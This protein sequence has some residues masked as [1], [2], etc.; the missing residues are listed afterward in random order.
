M[1][2]TLLFLYKRFLEALIILSGPLAA[3]AV[4]IGL[5]LTNIEFNISAMM[6]MTMIPGIV[7]EVSVFYFSELFR[8][9]GDGAHSAR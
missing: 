2:L 3:A 7:T 9:A 1:F 6:G 4:F 5:W 8:H